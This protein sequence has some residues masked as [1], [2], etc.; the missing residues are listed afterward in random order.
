MS[1]VFKPVRPD[2]LKDNPFQLIGGDW[3]LVTAGTKAN[4]N[5]MT[6]SWGG[7]G[8][9]W[10]KNIAICFVRP[11]RHTYG[12]MENNSHF[13]LTF[14]DEEFRDKLAFCGAH[15]GKDTDKTAKTGLTPVEGPAGTVFF[16]QA[17]LVL[18]CKKIY[19]QDLIPQHFLDPAIREFYGSSDFH[20]MYVGEIVEA[21]AK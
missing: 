7:L 12:F 5:M 9:L 21:L 14:F 20:R 1:H 11:T 15:S 4:Y 17:R 10:D 13:T 8:V 6:A 19:F 16:E 18:V 2:T 3:M